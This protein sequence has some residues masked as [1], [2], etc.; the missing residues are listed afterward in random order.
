VPFIPQA[1][2]NRVGEMVDRQIR[3]LIRGNACGAPDG[4]AAFATLVGKLKSAAGIDNAHEPLVLPSKIANAFA[5][6]GGK[7]Y[8]L[9][10]LLEK[11]QSPDEL[12]GVLAHELGH[13]KHRDGMRKLI[14]DGGTSFLIGLLFG[15]VTGAGAVLFAG[16]SVLDAS[17][18]RDAERDADA[19]ASQ[20]MGKLG[21]SAAPLGELLL[22]IPGAQ[23]KGISTILDSH[24]LTEERLDALKKGQSLV[25]RNAL[26][27]DGE[28]RALKRI[29]RP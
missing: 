24:P 26:L 7:I 21:R 6:P 11:A 20:T 3:F 12:A 1:W 9:D 29:C 18:S 10:G 16:R 15:D 8:V 19:F 22:R 25:T 4:Q 17:Y 2:E 28:W 13:V 23:A 5:L 27:S 14:H